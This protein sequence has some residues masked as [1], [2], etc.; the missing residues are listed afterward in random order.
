M[1]A[2]IIPLS[3]AATS[4]SPRPE[5][6]GQTAEGLPQMPSLYIATPAYGCQLTT[7]YMQCALQ[8]Q[9]VLGAKGYSIALDLLGNESLITRA[10][11]L[12]TKRFLMSGASHLLFID[13]D[14][15]WSPEAI[16]RLVQKNEPVV[17]GVYPKKFIDWG[18][19]DGKLKAGNSREPVFMMGLDYNINVMETEVQVEQ[20]F[21]KVMDAATGFMLIKREA[22]EKLYA[23]YEK[24]L[25]V[26]N[27]LLG[28]QQTVKDYVAIFDCMICPDTRRYLSEDFAFSRR[29]QAIGGKVYAD[30]A[31]P[32]GHTGNFH[33]EGD[34]GER[35]STRRG[36]ERQLL[37]EQARV[38]RERIARADDEHHELPEGDRK[39]VLLAL[40]PSHTDQVSLGFV[41][42]L[43]RTVAALRTTDRFCVQVKVFSSKNAACDFLWNDTAL[44]TVLLVDGTLAFEPELIVDML[45]S[46]SPLEVGVYPKPELDWESVTNEEGEAVRTRGLTYSIALPDVDQPVEKGRIE[47]PVAG[48]DLAKIDK[49]VLERVRERLPPQCRFADNRHCMWFHEG[50]MDDRV[51]TADEMFCRV[52]QAGVT[53]NMTRGVARLGNMTFN[54]TVLARD[55]LR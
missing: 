28:A 32:L 2:R 55:R 8:T 30:L 15:S 4:G 31:V 35:L 23:A 26:T 9:L 29:W 37:A 42:G 17:T 16:E 48:L 45:N 12:L 41:L 50:I 46:A 1:V 14:I 27:D 21:A 25:L 47:V 40:L 24:E 36:R 10:R 18:A 54:G 38:E 39:K 53:A 44:E 52:W 33:Y 3:N 22:I 43:T 49:C 19:L 11:N 51:L 34:L 13:A 20:G 7:Q 6:R 5:A